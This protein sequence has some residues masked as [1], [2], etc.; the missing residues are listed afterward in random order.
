MLL[1][2]KDMLGQ[3]SEKETHFETTVKNQRDDSW[4]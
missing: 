1:T 2:A 3:V 4:L